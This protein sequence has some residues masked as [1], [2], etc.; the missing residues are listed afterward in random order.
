MARGTRD[1][2]RA[3]APAFW[4][5]H[6]PMHPCAQSRGERRTHARHMRARGT[7]Q[8]WPTAS[9]TSK[10][11]DTA[12]PRRVD[13]ARGIGGERRGGD[14]SAGPCGGGVRPQG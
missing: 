14:G 1:S 9:H 10:G 3:P 2:E 6:A 4:P 8:L 13:S 12:S 11:G 7:G 5:R